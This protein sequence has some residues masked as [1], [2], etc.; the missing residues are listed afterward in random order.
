MKDEPTIRP[1]EWSMPFREDGSGGFDVRPWAPRSQGWRVH[2]SKRG[3]VTLQVKGRQISGLRRA[4][5]ATLRVLIEEALERDNETLTSPEI[6]KA[7][8]A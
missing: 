7:V 4:D 2:V 6:R 3:R 8:G 1:G 5:L